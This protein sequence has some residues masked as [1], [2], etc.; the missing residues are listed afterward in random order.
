MRRVFSI[1]RRLFAGAAGAEP[2]LQSRHCGR[3]DIRSGQRLRGKWPRRSV[4]S[5]GGE[6]GTPSSRARC[7]LVSCKVFVA[8]AKSTAGAGP[9][10]IVAAKTLLHDA[11]A[12]AAFKVTVFEAQRRL[13][14][15][16]PLSRDD[17]DGL[18]SPLMLANQSKHTVQ[19]S[20]L[21]WEPGAPRAAAGLADRPVPSR[22]T[23]S[24]T[25]AARSCASGAASSAPS[26]P[27]TAAGPSA[28]RAARPAS[29][30]A[31]SCAPATLASRTCREA[32]GRPG[33]SRR[34]QQ[35][36]P[37]SPG[38]PRQVPQWRR[39]DLSRRR[40]VLRRRDGR[41]DG[42]PA[43]VGAAQPGREPGPGRAQVL[44]PPPGP[45]ARVDLSLLHIA[46]G[47]VDRRPP[48]QAERRPNYLSHAVGVK[49]SVVGTR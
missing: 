32:A 5:V 6:A 23:G 9:S 16:W 44:G 3:A 15:L 18:V 30:T 20:D 29:S 41:H 17:G 38:P 35:P 12:G 19:F 25:A 40:P 31:S 2:G 7:S 28:C 42:E 1:C 11:P 14:G 33:D 34:P 43:V 21:A 4:S 8:D 49:A 13:G 27:P 45:A 47:R 22:A 24:A 39:Q 10:G 36:A 26:S 48:G 46:K 37:P